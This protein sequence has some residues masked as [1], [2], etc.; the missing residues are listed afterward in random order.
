MAAI[1]KVMEKKHGPAL[2]FKDHFIPFTDAEKEKGYKHEPEQQNFIWVFV[3][4]INSL[5]RAQYK[6]KYISQDLA[7]KTGQYFALLHFW[8]HWVMRLL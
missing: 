5:W 7:L 8:E 6:Y 3:D 4:K 1:R 2:C